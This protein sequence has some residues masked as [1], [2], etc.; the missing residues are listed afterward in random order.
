VPHVVTGNLKAGSEAPHQAGVH[1]PEAP[2][3]DV[4]GQTQPFCHR[5]HVTVQQVVPIKRLADP[6]GKNQVVRLAERLVTSPHLPHRPENDSVLVVRNLSFTC[7]R[8]HLV[9]LI[10]V[11]A[12]IYNNAIAKNIGA[13]TTRPGE[14]SFG[15]LSETPRSCQALDGQFTR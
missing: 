4:P 15:H 12:L 6:V 8:L 1:G 2:E 3:V 9:E 7:S 11:N 13:A 14:T 10:V 5:L